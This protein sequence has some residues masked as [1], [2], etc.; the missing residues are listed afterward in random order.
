MTTNQLLTYRAIVTDSNLEPITLDV[1]RGGA[2]VDLTI[3]TGTITIRDERSAALI[4]ENLPVA[5]NANGR[6][7]YYF[8]A[9][10]VALITKDSVWL[11]EWKI[12]APDGKAHRLYKARLPVRVKL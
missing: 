8:T 5:L 9:E 10:Q 12:V 2:P 4:A 3:F 1:R 6:A 11:V 7:E